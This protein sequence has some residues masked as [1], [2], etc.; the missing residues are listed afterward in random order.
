MRSYFLQIPRRLIFLVS[1][2]YTDKNLGLED[3]NSSVFVRL[4]NITEQSFTMKA[5]QPCEPWSNNLR[6]VRGKLRPEYTNINSSKLYCVRNFT[7]A[8]F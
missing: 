3:K 7:D 1:V 2:L 4:T 6:N 5:C 8:A